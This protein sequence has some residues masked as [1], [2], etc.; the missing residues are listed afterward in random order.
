[1]RLYQANAYNKILQHNNSFF[2]WPRQSGKS[3]LLS[4]VISDFVKNNIDKDILFFHNNAKSSNNGRN[5]LLQ[6][7]GDIIMSKIR[8]KN[9][10]NFIN[11]NY[12]EFCTLDQNYQYL[13][14]RNK[15]SLIIYD[16]LCIN[17]INRLID[18]ELDIDTFKIKTIFTSTYFDTD[19]IRLLDH[20]NN[21]YVNILPPFLEKNT[22][23]MYNDYKNMVRSKLNYKS[24]E[25][26]DFDDSYLR[27]EKIKQLNKIANGI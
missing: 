13:L 15:P 18:L 12:L 27:I 11:N 20:R 23:K 21:F 2:I 9:G 10:L 26:I 16:D 7:L 6:D 4:Y 19:A 8:N 14:F 5:K 1:M 3:T 24:K 25:L 22:Y 17:N